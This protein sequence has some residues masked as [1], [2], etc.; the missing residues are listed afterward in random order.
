MSHTLNIRICKSPRT[1]RTTYVVLFIWCANP[2]YGMCHLGLYVYLTWTILV[3]FGTSFKWLSQIFILIITKLGLTCFH[4]ILFKKYHVKMFISLSY[5][6]IRMINLLWIYIYIWCIV[7]NSKVPLE[8]LFKMINCEYSS[9]R[10]AYLLHNFCIRQ[11]LIDVF[12]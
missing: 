5:G 12:R 7:I 4:M 1:V 6:S 9:Y 11:N 3:S 8:N 2:F 10:L